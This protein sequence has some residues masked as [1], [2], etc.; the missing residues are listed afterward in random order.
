MVEMETQLD[1]FKVDIKL[2][3]KDS[4]TQQ[5]ILSDIQAT[6]NQENIQKLQ[7]TIEQMIQISL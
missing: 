7:N 1:E 5:K 4:A 6:Q 3:V 2:Q